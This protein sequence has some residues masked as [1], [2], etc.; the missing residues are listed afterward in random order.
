LN[1]KYVSASDLEMNASVEVMVDEA[2]G[3]ELVPAEV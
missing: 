3:S 1:P 2:N